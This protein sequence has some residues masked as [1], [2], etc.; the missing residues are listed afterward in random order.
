M[1]GQV[2]EVVKSKCT[3]CHRVKDVSFYSVSICNDCH[4]CPECHTPS[5]ECLRTE[6]YIC[7]ATLERRTG[8]RCAKCGASWRTRFELDR[9]V[10]HYA[11][12]EAATICRVCGKD[13]YH[14]YKTAWGKNGADQPCVCQN[15]LDCPTCHSGA[16]FE[17][18]STGV[19]CPVCKSDWASA[20]Q[21]EQD[22]GL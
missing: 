9:A 14:S 20:H 22:C 2:K 8:V 11:Y 13:V 19:H 10:V 5:K 16:I 17:K 1:C 7:L 21:F 6:N 18:S 4:E 12:T 15:C 3:I